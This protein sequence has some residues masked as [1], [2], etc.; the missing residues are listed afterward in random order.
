MT[1]QLM[2]AQ[3]VA[4][5]LGCSVASV[6]RYARTGKIPAPIKLGCLTRWRQAELEEFISGISEVAA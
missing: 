5:S 6:W 3:E 2:S 4:E 1:H